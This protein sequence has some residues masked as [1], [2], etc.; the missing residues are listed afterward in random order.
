MAKLVVHIAEIEL[1]EESGMGRVSWHWKEEFER[2]GFE[3]FH[4]G[5]N[6]V[7]KLKHPALFPYTARHVYH[8]LKR[9]VSLLL[10]HEPVSGAFL[11][12]KVPKVLF[13]HGIERRDWQLRLVRQKN[14]GSP[15]NPK[16]RLLFPL[17]RLR[18]CDL[19]LTH[20]DLLLLINKEDANFA[21][22]YY[23]QDDRNMF[24]FKNGVTASE[25]DETIYKGQDITVLFLGNWIERKGIKTLVSAARILKSQNIQAHWILAG[26]GANAE[27]VISNWDIDLRNSVE[28]IP[29][30][31]RT[32][33][34]ELFARSQ[35]FV[36]PSLFEGQPLALLQAMA[37]GRCC[38][39]T[40]CCGQRDLITNGHNGFLFEPGNAEQLASLIKICVEDEQLRLFLGNNAKLAVNHR[41][42][43]AV[44]MEVV[45]RIEKLICA[46]EKY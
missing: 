35:V 34:I 14:I 2:R 8:Q 36:L 31:S 43:Q 7:G 37:T 32:D 41:S 28:V 17:W 6:Q 23:Q 9:D 38:I 15:V 29:R 44:S 25:I 40:N 4:I 21:K 10:L 26:T 42:W 45:D 13:S 22:T 39:T 16:T 12:F 30:F 20:S 46:N 19:G 24:V 1:S 5:L 27:S 3:F 33:E 11:D 18:F